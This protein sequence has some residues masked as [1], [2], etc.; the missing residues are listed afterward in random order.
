MGSREPSCLYHPFHCW[1]CLSGPWKRS[2]K[3][4]FWLSG[5]W[6]REQKG[7]VLPLRTVQKGAERPRFASQNSA[8]GA[9][10]PRFA[11]QDPPKREQKDL[12]LPLR[13]PLRGAERPPFA[14]QD[15]KEE[16]G[17]PWY[18][19][20]YTLGIPSLPYMPVCRSS[21][22]RPATS[23]S[24]CTAREPAVYT[25]QCDKCALLTRG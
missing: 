12:V 20:W 5:P 17:I 10:R 2:R 14:S 1:S 22:H 11:S 3:S 24:A 6:K 9:E 18:M 19:P 21:S 4:S 8:K 25:G 7:L 16:G 13:T 15:P 23:A